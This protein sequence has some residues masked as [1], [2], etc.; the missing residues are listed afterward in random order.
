M[1]KGLGLMFI[2]VFNDLAQKF[3]P[4]I[5][6]KQRNNV[7]IHCEAITILFTIIYLSDL[8]WDAMVM[9]Y[10]SDLINNY[11][12]QY[13]NFYDGLDKSH[14]FNSRSKLIGSY[15]RTGSCLFLSTSNHH[16]GLTDDRR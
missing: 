14:A 2:Q 13:F 10:L 7:S 4:S 3:I 12:C 9:A 16:C 5:V 15:S 1:H 6:S 8:L 11:I